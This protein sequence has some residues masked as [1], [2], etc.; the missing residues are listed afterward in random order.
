MSY[1][2]TEIM[3]SGAAI[4]SPLLTSYGLHF[5]I[6]PEGRGSGGLSCEAEFSDGVRVLE[7]HF[8]YSLGLVTYHRAGQKVSHRAYMKALGIADACAYPGFSDD[9]LDGFRHLRSD[10]ERFGDDFLAG[11]GLVLR[12]AAKAE[13]QC[14]EEKGRQSMVASVG[15]KRSRSEA[16]EQ[17]RTKNYSR[18]IELLVSLKYPDDL[19]PAERKMLELAKKKSGDD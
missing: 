12:G 14:S 13:S 6:G 15:D 17:F 7:L 9:P 11:D 19:G 2:P 8:R 5:R 1:S 4:L 3:K 10:L 18:V 16:R